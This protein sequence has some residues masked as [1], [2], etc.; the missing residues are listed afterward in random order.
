M[1][2]S[3]S[4]DDNFAGEWANVKVKVHRQ[5]YPVILAHKKIDNRAGH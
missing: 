2:L 5:V 3:S 1:D 4:T